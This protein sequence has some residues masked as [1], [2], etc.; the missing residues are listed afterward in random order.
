[1]EE[2]FSLCESLLTPVAHVL[3]K[4]TAA[5]GLLLAIN[6]LSSSGK[7]IYTHGLVEKAIYFYSLPPLNQPLILAFAG[8]IVQFDE[9]LGASKQHQLCFML[10][11]LGAQQL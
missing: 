10:L 4:P 5:H 11:L 2:Y 8:R 3:L 9:T 1:M 7:T 6:L